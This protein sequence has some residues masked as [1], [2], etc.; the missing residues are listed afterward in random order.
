MMSKSNLYKE[1][2]TNAFMKERKSFNI[3][4]NNRNALIMKT[5]KNWL[6]IW[7]TFKKVLIFINS[8]LK[9]KKKLIVYL[10]WS[11]KKKNLFN[12]WF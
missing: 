7:K 2:L 11:N 12:Y 4:Y 9:V 1:F 5:C 8:S 3:I 10:S 6:L